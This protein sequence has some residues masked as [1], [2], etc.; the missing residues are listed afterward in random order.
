M[1]K[2]TRLLS[3]SALSAMVL[4]SAHRPSA[5]EEEL[6]WIG[7]VGEGAASLAYGLAESDYVLLSLACE[8]A[9]GPVMVYFPHEP[10]RS[11]DGSSYRLILETGS[12]AVTIETTGRRMEMDDLFILEGEL[13]SGE[14]LKALLGGTESLK[15]SVAGHVTELPLATAG[16][17]AR[18]F[19]AVCAP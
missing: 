7:W 14:E 19:L 3:A 9:G 13:Q 15:I 5:A 8:K 6:T 18:E 10:E 4:V 1:K 12:R 11:K 2:T 17:A 16:E